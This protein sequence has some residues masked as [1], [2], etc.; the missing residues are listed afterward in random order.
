MIHAESVSKALE[1]WDVIQ[2]NDEK[3]KTFYQAGPGNVPTQVAFS[4]DKRWPD[5]DVDREN[6]CIRNIDHAF[7]VEAPIGHHF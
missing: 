4:Q 6:G 7:S 2:T 5:L 1:Q 3:V